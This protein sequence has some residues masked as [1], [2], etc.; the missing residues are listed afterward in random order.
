MKKGV[1]VGLCCSFL[2]FFSIVAASGLPEKTKEEAKQFA[3]INPKRV[4][5]NGEVGKEIKAIVK[6]SPAVEGSFKI[7]NA[8][9]AK[10][11]N[12]IITLSEAEESGKTVY[13]LTVENTKK[14]LGTYVD[15]IRLVTSGEVQ[16]E[17]IIPVRGKIRPPQVASVKP[18]NLIL[19]GPVGKLIK[20]SV[21]IIPNDEY[22]F[23]ITD[24]LAYRGKEIRWDLQKVEKSGKKMYVLTVEN[25]REKKGRYND[26]ILLKTDSK[27]LPKIYITISARISD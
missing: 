13:L 11:E 26:I 21:E 18:N 19:K 24:V 7:L 25:L 20:A 17:I 16:K 22:P 5:L 27:Y 10:G 15:T 14:T 6:I 4:Y 3:T 2:F 12:I 1:F 8:K 9:A 23:L